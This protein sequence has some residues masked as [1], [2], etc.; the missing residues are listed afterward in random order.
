MARCSTDG[1]Q[2]SRARAWLSSVWQGESHSMPM[3][4]RPVAGFSMA[5]SRPKASP[6]LALLACQ[7]SD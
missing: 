1:R 5:K 3:A 7:P 6:S 4:Y 2:I